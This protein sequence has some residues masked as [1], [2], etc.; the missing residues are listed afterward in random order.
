[1]P[2]ANDIYFV[3]LF[4]QCLGMEHEALNLLHK[5]SIAKPQLRPIIFIRVSERKYIVNYVHS[6]F[7]LFLFVC[8]LDLCFIVTKRAKQPYKTS[9][10]LNESTQEIINT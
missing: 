4:G 7:C 3:H 6:I 5:S 10:F 1:M 2:G 9:S 8:L